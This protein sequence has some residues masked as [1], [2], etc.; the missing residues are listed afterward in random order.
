MYRESS[1]LYL[2]TSGRNGSNPKGKLCL[3]EKVLKIS[4]D[5]RLKVNKTHI[6]RQGTYTKQICTKTYMFKRCGKDFVSK[7]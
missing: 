5:P 4:C 1:K 6:K 2:I 3:L 7:I